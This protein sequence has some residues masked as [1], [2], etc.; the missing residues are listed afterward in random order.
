SD[1]LGGARGL[2]NFYQIQHRNARAYLQAARENINAGKLEEARTLLVAAEAQLASANFVNVY[3]ANESSVG[4]RRG[5]T[6]T[7]GY[8]CL[9]A[10]PIAAIAGL[11]VGAT[12]LLSSVGLHSVLGTFLVQ[13]E[14]D[15]PS[16]TPSTTSPHVLAWLVERAQ[17]GLVQDGS[18]SGKLSNG[19][20]RF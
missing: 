9:G 15:G 6:L 13:D 18:P 11:G 8:G 1:L 4:A 17:Q 7:I 19:F 3:Y 12:V 20:D 2:R 10:A 5:I 14:G 16:S